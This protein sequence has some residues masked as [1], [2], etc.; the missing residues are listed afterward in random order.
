MPCIDRYL[1]VSALPAAGW[2]VR[3]R[4]LGELHGGVSGNFAAAAARLGADVRAFGWSG[5]DE[6]SRS[7]VDALRAD[8]VD[9]SGI[10][11]RA[12]WPVFRTTVLVDGRGERSVVLLPPVAGLAPEPEPFSPADLRGL[13]LALCY[14][15]PWD[16]QA[17]AVAAAAREAGA[18]VAATVESD[19]NGGA[20]MGW[21]ALR[22]V[23]LLFLSEETA[24][25]FGLLGRLPRELVET[26]DPRPQVVVITLGSAG[27]R[28]LTTADGSSVSA[29]GF[30]V[31]AV[32]TTGAGDTFA[33][34]F[35][36]YWVEGLRGDRLLEHANAAGALATT[37]L[38]PR[39]GMPSRS[40]L[41]KLVRSKR[42]G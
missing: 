4:D 39:S 14:V 29:P 13:N 32:D 22:T 11:A 21:V 24:E 7:S 31:V 38:G 15:G 27:A 26:P 10:R 1:T 18:L 19:S 17:A 30:D 6:A 8:G 12:G 35:C 3:G 34:A 16:G 37:A 23:D 20:G 2:K 5:N 41:E 28:Y 25:R 33:A 42:G 36:T 40:R 9:V